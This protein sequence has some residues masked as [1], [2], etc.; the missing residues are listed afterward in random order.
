MKTLKFLALAALLLLTGISA[1]SLAAN[2]V[3]AQGVDI[4]RG[5]VVGTDTTP[6]QGVLVVATTLTG[7]NTRQSRT[8]K[9]GRYTITF[10]GGEG[11]YWV[12]FTA[13]GFSAV[14]RQVKRTADQEILIADA[15]MSAS[16]VN[17]AQFNVT[18]RTAASRQDTVSDVGGTEKSLSAV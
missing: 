14:R 5:R 7:D 3:A 13:L 2:P 1:V 15:R 4:I 10:P 6:V 17:L 9:N 18:E 12:T 8:D 11:D 16:A